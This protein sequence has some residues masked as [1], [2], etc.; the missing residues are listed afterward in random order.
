MTGHSTEEE[1][2]DQ[3]L[4]NMQLA[5][6]KHGVTKVTL[7]FS[8]YDPEHVFIQLIAILEKGNIN[9]EKEG[10]KKGKLIYTKVW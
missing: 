9:F 5:P 3:A 6:Y 7:F 4:V 1:S 2:K 10:L 8:T